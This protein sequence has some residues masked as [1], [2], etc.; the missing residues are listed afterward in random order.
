MT[1]EE[2][3]RIAYLQ[4]QGLGYKRIASALGLPVNSV[5]S[6]CRRH[7][8]KPPAEGVC[9]V[10]GAILVRVLH[11]K[12]KKFCSDKCRMVWWNSHQE[13][14]NRKAIYHLHCAHCGQPFD[15]YGNKSRKY[16]SRRCYDDA[17]R[18]GAE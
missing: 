3:K 13:L 2:K 18:K 16:C 1:N 14:V 11:R 4:S 10:C 5:K 9:P 6:F 17:R 8:A 12:P 15:S 7:P